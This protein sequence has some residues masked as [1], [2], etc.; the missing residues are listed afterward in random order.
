MGSVEERFWSKVDKRSIEECWEWQ[1]CV[2]P[3]GYGNLRVSGRTEGA[4]RVAFRIAYGDIPHGMYVCHTCDN[5]SCVNPAHL[6]LSD[7]RGN[8]RD[9]VNKGRQCKGSQHGRAKLTETQ[10]IRMREQYAQGSRSMQSLATEYGIHSST[11][12]QIVNRQ[13]WKHV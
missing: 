5:R 7:H 1:A 12:S 9:K 11:V 10:V 6:F 8:Q 4:H 2:G 3:L 13:R